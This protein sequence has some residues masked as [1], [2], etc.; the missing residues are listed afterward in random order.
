MSFKPIVNVIKKNDN[1]EKLALSLAKLN[2]KDILVGIPEAE[3]GNNDKL[4]NAQLLFIHSNGS[5]AHNLPERKT[6]EPTIEQERPYIQEY[7]GNAIKKSLTGKDYTGDLERIGL[8]LQNKARAKFGSDELAPLAES[9]KEQ[10]AKKITKG[11][12][13]KTVKQLKEDF[14]ASNGNPLIATGE[15]QKSVTYVIRNK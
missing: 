1:F 3:S 11:K 4:T 5:P 9:T 2:N 6:I 7:F 15:L 12:K 10:K 8:H 14:I 13:G